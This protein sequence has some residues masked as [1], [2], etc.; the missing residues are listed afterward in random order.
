M[1]T[2]TYLRFLHLELVREFLNWLRVANFILYCVGFFQDS[3]RLSL[4]NPPCLKQNFLTL[5]QSGNPEQ[6]PIF[7]TKTNE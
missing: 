1:K 5:A 6:A 3:C 2:S 7:H 4:Q